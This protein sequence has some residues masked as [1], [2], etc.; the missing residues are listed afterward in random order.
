MQATAA[1]NLVFVPGQ[2]GSASAL[3]LQTGA[4]R[5]RF[6]TGGRLFAP[7]TI[8]DDRCYIGSCDGCIYC[9]EAATGRELWRY[10]VAP[11]DR[12]IMVYG[13]LMSTWPI[14]GGVLVQDGVVYAAAGIL[15]VDGTYVAALDARSGQVKWRNDRSGHLDATRDTGVAACGFPAIFKGRLWIRSVSYD[16]AT[17]A[18]RASV[19]APRPAAANAN[20]W[21]T[22]YTGAVTRY[23]GLLERDTGLFAHQFLVIGGQRFFDDQYMLGSIPGTTE[24][25]GIH[26]TIEFLQLADDATGKFPCV[27]PWQQCRISARLG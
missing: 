18:C 11:M 10:R 15:D 22:H 6:A 2:D 1:G 9:L 3:D 25:Q 12:R 26:N 20:L 8:A 16:L 7:P 19:D 5:W 27:V 13:D 24:D 4:V 17:G 21:V 23:S 14:T